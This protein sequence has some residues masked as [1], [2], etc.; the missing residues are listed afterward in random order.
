MTIGLAYPW[1]LLLLLLPLLVAWLFPPHREER[2]GLVVP[3]LSRLSEHTG[4]K[5][6]KGALVLR[7]GWIRKLSLVLGW[8][9]IVV[10]LARPQITEPPVTRD[11]PVRDMLLAVDLSGSMETKD[12]KNA[13]GE[14]VDRLTA[15][16][17]VLDDFLL[18][19]KGDRVGLILFG[20]APF[21][22]VPFT[23]DLNVCRQLLDEAQT[24]MA[25]PQTAFGDALGLAINVFDR[26]TVK[27]RVLIALTDG[28]DT[29]SQVPPAKAASIAKDKGIVIHTVAVGDPRAAGE[30]A[31]DEE[32]L[33]NV[34][35]TTGGLFSHA[36]DRKQLAEIYR[37]LDK[38]ETRKAQTI[39][40]RP[41]RDVYWW[42]LAVALVLSL[43]QQVLQLVVHQARARA[44]ARRE[45]AL[46]GGATMNPKD[47]PEEV[48]A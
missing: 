37:K 45:A 1:M 13:K 47:Q 6:K 19:R 9:C 41:R 8:A 44:R 20:N 30:D 29:A 15:V 42:P 16:K 22:Q 34:A 38:L 4:Q 10:A 2:Q 17:E 28:N 3:F 40:H 33:K 31:L 24:K 11:V 21:V 46:M 7:G 43:V 26:S 48:A 25:G 32:T 18:R 27:E 39:S 12:F 14:T 23:E 35:S 5:P 36:T